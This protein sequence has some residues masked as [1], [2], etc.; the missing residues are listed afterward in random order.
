MEIAGGVNNFF[1]KISKYSVWRNP[2]PY[3]A[4]RRLRGGVFDASD[5]GLD[6]IGIGR[7]IPGR[8]LEKVA[9]PRA[10]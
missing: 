3:H 7:I 4:L 2:L 8:K 9:L 5:W 10:L 6:G 1:G